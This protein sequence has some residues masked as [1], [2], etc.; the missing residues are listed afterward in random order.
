MLDDLEALGK[1]ALAA[2]LTGQPTTTTTTTTTTQTDA[3]AFGSPAE[4]A[5]PGQLNPAFSLWLMGYPPEWESCAPPAM[6]SSRKP[7][8]SS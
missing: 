7:R 8:P 4:T 6:R 2:L 5:K 1:L 3:K